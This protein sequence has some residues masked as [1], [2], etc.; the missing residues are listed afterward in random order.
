MSD[1][2][3]ILV[4]VGYIAKKRL[5]WLLHV[6]SVVKKV[7]ESKPEGRIRMGRPRLR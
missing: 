6:I 3:I 1:R 2:G 4:I 7:F 5:E